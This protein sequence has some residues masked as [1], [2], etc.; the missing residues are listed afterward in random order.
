MAYLQSQ[1]I[2]IIARPKRFWPGEHWGVQLSDGRV[3]HLT[4]EGVFLINLDVFLEGK[5]LREVRLADPCRNPQIMWRVTEALRSPP[6][7]RFAD[8]NCETFANQL[9]GDP[10][11][12]PQATGV[13][14]I[15]LIALFVKAAS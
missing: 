14:L 6:R 12:S 3:I 9:L 13:A 2:R 8:Q 7:Y 15:A 1:R 5:K 4:L 11:D 10:P